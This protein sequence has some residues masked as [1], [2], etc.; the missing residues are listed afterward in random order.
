MKPFWVVYA[1]IALILGTFLF[2]FTF[3][4]SAEWE[5]LPEHGTEIGLGGTY[6]DGTTFFNGTAIHAGDG[7]WAGLQA[8]KVKEYDISARL[9]GGVDFLGLGELQGFIEMDIEGELQDS[10]FSQPPKP[11][12]G[13]YYRRVEEVKDLKALFGIGTLAYLEDEDTA[14][15]KGWSPTPYLLAILGLE[16]NFS[17]NVDLYGRLVGRPGGDAFIGDLTLGLQTILS[18]KITFK[19]QAV[20]DV[21]FKYEDYEDGF[22]FEPKVEFLLSLNL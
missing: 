11:S 22:G 4:C 20:G 2:L 17:D 3:T 16:Y 7:Y 15:D 21:D 13:F 9:Q 1:L 10:K 8:S 19:L 5:E 14:D 12:I 18:D 6:D